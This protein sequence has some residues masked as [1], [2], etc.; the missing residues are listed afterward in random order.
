MQSFPNTPDLQ[1]NL[2]KV[3]V[4]RSLSYQEFELSGVQSKYYKKQ[5]GMHA[6]IMHTSLQGEQE[7]YNCYFEKLG[8]KQQSLINHTELNN[9]FKCD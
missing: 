3:W 6:R 1:V 2:K 8:I 7:I 4:I 9:S 5:N